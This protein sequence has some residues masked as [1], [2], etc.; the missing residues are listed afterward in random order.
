MS[1]NSPSSGYGEK[2]YSPHDT[3][4]RYVDGKL[5]IEHV[6][7]DA[8]RGHS[9][10]PR[11]LSVATDNG[12]Q[13]STG[14]PR[15]QSQWDAM[16]IAKEGGVEIDEEI[17]LLEEELRNNPVPHSFFSPV[18]NFKNPAHFTWL[19]VGF[20]S[21]GGLLSGIDQSLISGANLYMPASLHLDTSQVSLVASGVPLGAIGG[22]LLLGP[23]NE[24]VG[25][26]MAIIISLILY[27]IGA[28]LEAGAISF[29]MIVAGRV[30]LGLGVGLEGGTV[31]V[32]VAESVARKYRGNLVSLYQFNIALGEVFGY[33]VAAIFV[34]VKSGSWRYMLGSS[35]IFSTIM[36]AGMFFMPESPRFL[37]HKGRTLEAFNVWK[38]I[39]GTEL[40][41]N[42]E[43]FFVMKHS[44][45]NE[46]ESKDTRSGGFAWLD[47]ITV[48]RARRSIIYANIM[49]FLG[50]FTGINAIMYYMATLMN[51]V[52][53]D[54]KQSVFM[55][56]VGGGSL[57]LGTIPAIFYME[58]FGRR[59]WA[60][61]M[62]PGFFLG[63]LII[64][65]SYLIDSK[66]NV[67]GAEGTYITGLILYEGFFGS[68]AC[69]TWVLP[70]EVY[71]TYLR[72]YGMETSDVTLFFCS[73]LVTYFFSDM[74]AAM[75]R[76][77]LT[78]GFY[79]GIAVV[80]WFYQLAFMPETKNKTLEEIDI[81]FSQPT[82]QLVKQNLKGVAENMSDL[83]HGRW[84]RV[85][86]P[87]PESPLP[88]IHDD[89]PV[90][91]IS[92]AVQ[93]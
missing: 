17:E 11:N 63:L 91:P 38:R 81:L 44:V 72:S 54:S 53:F 37:M 79:G 3:M 12:R 21:M 24:A 5:E 40:Q 42:R 2:E 51:Q 86:K 26:R 62:L 10:V 47:F 55:S 19:L 1:D 6:E 84:G 18:I 14:G 59:F 57:L 80:G 58:R 41:E 61:A 35:L 48:P 23:L 25:R 7:P 30:I 34:N 45:L 65:C 74:E 69:L 68:Y 9:M 87:S 8:R 60:C 33:V 50:Q 82:S 73:W 46:L 36:L 85:F 78:L 28:A 71:P 70:A 66:T 90:G 4:E 92:N 43:E 89:T 67:G 22:A 39:R 13:Y 75:S 56:L 88:E 64:G 93:G 29:G 27:T 16:K 49:I 31:P 15:R 32:Y 77:G 83:A 76:I 52:G 20:A